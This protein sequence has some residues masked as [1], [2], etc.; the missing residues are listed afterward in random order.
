MQNALLLTLE[1]VERNQAV[2]RSHEF[3]LGASRARADPGSPP[4]VSRTRGGARWC[5]EADV[6]AGDRA[7]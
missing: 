7:M 5:G 2:W 4:G 3:R 1:R 6:R